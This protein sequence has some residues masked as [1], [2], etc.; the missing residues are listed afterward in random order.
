MHPAR[1]RRGTAAAP[2]RDFAA[3]L[4]GRLVLEGWTFLAGR[5]RHRRHGERRA[6]SKHR[7]G[8]DQKNSN[9]DRMPSDEETTLINF[10]E[11]WRP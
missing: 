3:F 2:D 4:F 5:L 10:A 1:S 11:N 9:Q 8:H 6:K 7:H